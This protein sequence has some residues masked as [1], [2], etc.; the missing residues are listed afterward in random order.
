MQCLDDFGIPLLLS[1]TVVEV[2]GRERVEGVVIAQLDETR[3]PIP[4]TFRTVECDTLLLSV[5]LIPENELTREAGIAVNPVTNGPFVSQAMETCA[6]GIFACGNVV[7]VHDLV[8]YVTEESRIA[9]RGAARFAAGAMKKTARIETQAGHGVRYV[10]PNWIEKDG[11]EGDEKLLFRV[12]NV[13]QNVNLV[14]KTGEQEILRRHLASA[15]P[16]EM[17][18]VRLVPALVKQLGDAPLTVSLEES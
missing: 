8:D 11:L 14:V 15:A 6:E 16:G 2:L 4:E 18:S 7:H 10:V 1:H 5:G 3:K 12:D 17:E 9:G 13:Y